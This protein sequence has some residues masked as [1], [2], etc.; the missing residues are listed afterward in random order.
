MKLLITKLNYQLEALEALTQSMARNQYT[1]PV[2]ELG[3][4]SVGQHVR[5]TIEIIQALVNGY[6]GGEV[7]YEKRKRDLEIETAPE[8]AANLCRNLSF[9]TDRKDK[10]LFLIEEDTEASLS[11]TYQREVH[12]VLEHTIHHMALIKTALR[13]L[14]CDNTPENFGMAYSTIKYRAQ[15]CAQ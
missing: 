4:A 8:Y 5:H 15:S 11:T 9:L 10:R 12:F 2:F 3:N 1:M 7:N 13:I 14:K 6:L